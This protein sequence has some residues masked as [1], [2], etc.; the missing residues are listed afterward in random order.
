MEAPTTIGAVPAVSA[1]PE[2]PIPGISPPSAVP[3]ATCISLDEMYMGMRSNRPEVA[4]FQTT[5]SGRGFDPGEIDGYF[6]VNTMRAAVDDVLTSNIDPMSELFLDDGVV[7][8]T[9]FIRLGI[10]C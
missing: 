8:H 5:L 4:L 2:A 6:G 7:R 10:A 3:M 9:M 1:P